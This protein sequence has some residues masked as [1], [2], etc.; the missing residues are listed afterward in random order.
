M[1]ISWINECLRLSK[2]VKPDDF[3]VNDNNGEPGPNRARISTEPA[4]LFQSLEVCVKGKFV[5]MTQAEFVGLLI[6][7]GATVLRFVLSSF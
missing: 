6:D 5:T 1:G 2:L 7:S 4:K 3:E